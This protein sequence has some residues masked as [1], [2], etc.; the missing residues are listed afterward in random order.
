[1]ILLSQIVSVFTPSLVENK[2]LDYF[3]LE[4]YEASKRIIRK[5]TTLGT[6]VALKRNDAAALNQDDIL[7]ID[8]TTAIL[9]SILPCEC[10]AITPNSM[11]EMGSICYDIGNK[12]IPIFLEE[13]KVVIPYDKPT[14]E[15]FKKMGYTLER[16]HQKLTNALR[17]NIPQHGHFAEK[18][19]LF[20]KIMKL[21]Q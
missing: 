2:T 14:F 7:Y 5:K 19:G 11:V 21:T 16:S 10:I 12:H 17:T 4:W 13:N 15:Q 3:E 20:N 9:I 8:V 18:E 1:M 6:D